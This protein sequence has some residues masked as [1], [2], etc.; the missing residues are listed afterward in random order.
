MEHA[1]QFIDMNT[2]EGRDLVEKIDR[3]KEAMVN[4]GQ[5]LYARIKKSS[6][7]YYQ[8]DMAKH[9][10]KRWGWPM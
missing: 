4:Q 9:D 5:Q 3:E 6:K 2:Q 1:L 7:Y 10:P 8:N